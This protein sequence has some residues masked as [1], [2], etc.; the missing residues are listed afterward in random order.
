MAHLLTNKH[1]FP[2]I[3]VRAIRNDSYSRGKSDIS[4]TSLITPPFQRQLKERVDQIEDAADRIFSLLGSSVH[5]MIERAA[6]PDD[7]VE[8][9]FFYEVA[10]KIVSGQCDLLKDGVLYDFKVTSVWSFING[11]KA[12]WEQQL[13]LLR[14]LAAA[15]ANATNDDRYRADTLKIIAIFRDFQLFKA[16]SDGYPAAPA[17]MIDIPV[18]P[19]EQTADFL[20]ERVEAHF[21]NDP[22]P[23]TDEERWATPEVYAVMKRGRQSAVR[24]LDSQD[25]A[26][27]MA[28]E[29]GA[30]HYIELRPK[31]Y[32]RCEGYCSV[33][34]ECDVHN[35][36]GF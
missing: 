2:D 23:C 1:G 35:R 31:T 30:G 11:G 14:L 13:N 10:G 24:L 25:A 32:R 29:K 7:I 17:A 34:H 8:E 16:G 33:S 26:E 3:L 15:K 9:R 6:G 4:V 36:K 20:S 22:P 27:A 18:W 12:E 19:L 21:A 5:H 28:K